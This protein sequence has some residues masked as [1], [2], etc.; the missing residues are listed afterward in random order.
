MCGL[1]TNCIGLGRAC[2][3]KLVVMRFITLSFGEGTKQLLPFPVM[4]TGF[5]PLELP[6]C[7]LLQRG[8]E[9]STVRLV[10]I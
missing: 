6:T 8:R 5:G 10:L 9:H 4:T 2:A 3:L 7:G 1:L